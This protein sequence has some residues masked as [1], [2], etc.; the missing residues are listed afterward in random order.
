MRDIPRDKNIQTL[1]NA[2]TTASFFTVE[3]TRPECAITQY[4]LYKSTSAEITA[5]DT[6]LWSRLDGANYVENGNVKIQTNILATETIVTV[7]FYIAAKNNG[8]VIKVTP[9]ITVK[10]SCIG[11]SN[12]TSTYV[13]ANAVAN[14]YEWTN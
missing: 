6:A 14:V 2:T 13:T 1:F 4:L 7:V 10:L 8:N 11:V 12:V 3:D 5:A 9:G